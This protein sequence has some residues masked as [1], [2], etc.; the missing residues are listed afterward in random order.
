MSAMT[1][2]RPILVL[3][4][5]NLNMLG[6]REPHI[7]GHHTLGDVEDMCR[8]KAAELGVEVTFGQS[9]YEGELVGMIQQARDGASG[10]VI[11]PG[12]YTHT[13]V[14]IYDALKLAELPVIEVHLSNPHRREEF[15]H[16]SYISLV[17]DGIVAGF[18]ARSFVMAIEGMVGHLRQQ[19]PAGG[20]GG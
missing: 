10:I 11:N 20:S 1:G 2:L 6:V 15:R 8:A 14:A 13:S 16:H 9:N 5:P 19:A 7:Y 3:N 4:G 18:G 12:A 17:A